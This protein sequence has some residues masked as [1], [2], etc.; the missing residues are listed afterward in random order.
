VI[1]SGHLLAWGP[2]AI[3][4]P[5]THRPLIEF[6]QAI[7]PTQWVR[8]GQGRS[9]LRRA[10]RTYLP[11]EIAKRKG[12]GSP[13]EAVLRAVTR[14]WS[15]LRELLRDARVCDRGYVNPNTLKTLIEQPDFERTPE[16]LFVLR[17]SYLELWLRDLE[18]RS[19]ALKQPSTIEF[20]S[21]LAGSERAVEVYS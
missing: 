17:I 6:L 1:C 8:P 15:R 9:L 14:E 19:Q 12:K 11:E 5:F 20:S 21:R 18:R 4:Y 3:T 7:P 16:G 13:A 10:L 2:V